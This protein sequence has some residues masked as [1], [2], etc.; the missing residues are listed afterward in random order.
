MYPFMAILVATWFEPDVLKRG[1][2]AG[3]LLATPRNLFGEN[4]ENAL[5]EIVRTLS[6][7]AI[8][9][10]E[11]SDRIESIFKSL[12]GFEGS[13]QQLR[14]PLFELIVGHCLHRSEEGSVDINRDVIAPV[15]GQRVNIDVLHTQGTQNVSAYECKGRLSEAS[16][17][18]DEVED[19]ITRQVP[20]ILEYIRSRDELKNRNKI[21]FAFWTTGRFAP[22]AVSYLKERKLS[23]RRYSVDWKDGQEV[24]RFATENGLSGVVRMLDDYYRSSRHRTRTILSGRRPLSTL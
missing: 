5:K 11:E 15:A 1:R 22:D 13:M 16:I 4:I 14:G 2:D 18:R 24:R 19:W 10:T 8:V 3:I 17:S 6:D 20:R 7:A 21:S 9:A 23:T 12:S